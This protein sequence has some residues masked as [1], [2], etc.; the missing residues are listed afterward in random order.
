MESSLL[1]GSIVTLASVEAKSI[2]LSG[3]IS[4]MVLGLGLLPDSTLGQ[5]TAVQVVSPQ[6]HDF[7]RTSSQPGT[8]E[9]F[10]EADLGAKVSGYVEELL[11]DIGTRVTAGQVLARIA[12]PEMIEARNAI[13]ADVSALESQYDREAM[14]VE[15]GSLTQGAAEET[16]SRLAAALARQH[17]I[18]AQM[19]YATIQAPFDGVVT[20]RTIDPGDMIYEASSPKGG[21][22]PLL[23]VA[24]VDLIRVKTYLPEH[25][26][27]WAD[28]GDPATITF[29]ALPGQV[30]S[31]Q[32]ARV[33]GALDP[34]TRTMQVEIDL[35]NADG[36]I[37]PGL[38]GRTEITLEIR[39][40]VLALPASSVRF[41]E[42]GA[43]AYVIA[44]NGS[45]HHV[46][47]EIGLDDGN[48]LEVTSGLSKNDRVV[49]GMIGSLAEG[50]QVR[51]V[52]Q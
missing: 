36:R 30:F 4:V 42:E 7:V 44:D 3:L 22:Q 48:W 27:V 51:V 33:S 46:A 25:E 31:G 34:S 18:E 37:L 11:V 24:Q 15:R 26:T 28:I 47:V 23:K 29:D 45:A 39:R 21:D 10:Y 50:E 8:A 38:Y 16:K 41:S 43:Y 35:P 5:V 14:L 6:S 40:D 17:E 20:H 9:A 32:I 52:V 12:V 1:P 19:K 2:R 49:N 13:L